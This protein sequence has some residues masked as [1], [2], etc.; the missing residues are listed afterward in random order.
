MQAMLSSDLR[1]A[2]GVNAE[3]AQ[4]AP[5][6]A[7]LGKNTIPVHGLAAAPLPLSFDAATTCCLC[8]TASNQPW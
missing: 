8:T 1:W 4:C 2:R 5:V 3:G 6:R 7:K